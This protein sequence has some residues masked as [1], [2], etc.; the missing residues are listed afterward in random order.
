MLQESLLGITLSDPSAW[1]RLAGLRDRQGFTD[2][3]IAGWKDFCQT[4]CDHLGDIEK[5]S[6]LP[7]PRAPPVSRG[8]VVTRSQCE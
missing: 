7:S 3:F 1:G 2:V 4:A 6:A 8:S 5:R